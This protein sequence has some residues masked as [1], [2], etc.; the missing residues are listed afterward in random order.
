MELDIALPELLARFNQIFEA[1]E[2]DEPPDAQDFHRPAMSGLRRLVQ[3]IAEIH[4]VVDAMDFRRRIRT[5]LH[6]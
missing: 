4:S 5:P 2:S 6:H 3:K 1:L